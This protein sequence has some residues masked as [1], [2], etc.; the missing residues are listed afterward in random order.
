MRCRISTS[1]SMACATC[2][3]IACRCCC[4]IV[5]P[6]LWCTTA[7]AAPR[8][9]SASLKGAAASICRLALERRTRRAIPSH[10]RQAIGGKGDFLTDK[11]RCIGSSPVYT[12]PCRLSCLVQARD[13]T[14]QVNHFRRSP[15]HTLVSMKDHGLLLL[16]TLSPFLLLPTVVYATGRKKFQCNRATASDGTREGRH[17]ISNTASTPKCSGAPR[18][19]HHPDALTFFA[20][21]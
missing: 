12:Y 11:V 8:I 21:I 16:C 6:Y 19:C 14:L 7:A 15:V 1:L 9:F 4:V 20:Q 10:R 17:Y 5:V 18:G 2:S 13:D 3:T